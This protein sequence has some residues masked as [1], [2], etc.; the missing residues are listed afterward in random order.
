MSNKKYSVILFLILIC[1]T[2]YYFPKLYQTNN[3]SKN[4]LDITCNTAITIII[5][6][7]FSFYIV[8]YWEYLWK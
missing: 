2:Y 6:S 5:I 4:A 3:E 7:I 8:A 1:F